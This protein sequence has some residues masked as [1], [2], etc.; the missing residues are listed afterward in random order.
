[1]VGDHLQEL[2]D[3]GAP[4]LRVR[5]TLH[6]RQRRHRILV[7]D[8]VID[9]PPGGF[10]R[11]RSDALLAGD[12]DP[13]ARVSGTK[14]QAH[15]IPPFPEAGH[16]WPKSSSVASGGAE[17]DVW[18]Q[19]PMLCFLDSLR[20]D[21]DAAAPEW[22][23]GPGGSADA[24]VRFLK[25]CPAPARVRPLRRRL[26]AVVALALQHQGG[27]NGMRRNPMADSASNTAIRHEPRHKPKAHFEK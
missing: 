6:L 18:P 21:V 15:A 26:S 8:Q 4:S 20:A 23:P 9:R 24:G 11:R 17:P 1:M 16:R 3:D 14:M 25:R 7:D 13:A 5:A 19:G 10:T 12:E 22:W 2:S 27:G